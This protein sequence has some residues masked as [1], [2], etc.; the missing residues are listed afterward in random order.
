MLRQ[1]GH[2]RASGPRRRWADPRTWRRQCSRSQHCRH[3]S[4]RSGCGHREEPHGILRPWRSRCGSRCG[5]SGRC[6]GTGHPQLRKQSRMLGHRRA[7]GRRWGRGRRWGQVRQ[8]Q[9]VPE[10]GQGQQQVL[11][12]EQQQQ[13]EQEYDPSSLWE[14]PM[15]SPQFEFDLEEEMKFLQPIMI[16]KDK[17]IEDLNTIVR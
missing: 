11:G 17:Q 15:T 16:Q 10:Q 14:G 4:W 6:R 2:K 5:R 7:Q 3:G 13:L 12:W 1:A 8:K 9:L